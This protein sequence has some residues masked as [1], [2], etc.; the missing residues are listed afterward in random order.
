MHKGLWPLLHQPTDEDCA[1]QAAAV[2]AGDGGIPWLHGDFHES[3]YGDEP[4]HEGIQGRC[5]RSEKALTESAGKSSAVQFTGERLIPGASP[6]H[7]EAEHRARY[8]FALR[9]VRGCR[10]LDLGCGAG[11]G[12]SM[13][14]ASAT[15]VLGIDISEE[16]IEYARTHYIGSGLRFQAGDVTRLSIE[17]RRYEA[18]VCFE[19]IEHIHHPEEVLQRAARIL[20]N[21][22]IFISSTPN[23]AVKVSSIP[24]PFHCR[25]YTLN[26]YTS[27]LREQ[28]SDERWDID[29]FGQFF[30]GKTYTSLRTALKNTYLGVKG[31]LG[32]RTR[33]VAKR[34]EAPTV[35]ALSLFEFREREARL[36]EYLIAIVRSR[37]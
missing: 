24:N 10:V 29:I 15:E 3:C 28:F 31:V 14:L 19:V 22:G 7:L 33:L 16:A 30:K 27:L 8:E 6:S 37:G 32:L 11:Y 34:T 18:I 2:H 36:A 25:E 20:D 17:P 4:F 26:E 23:R 21:K 12:S 5:K 9:Y 1:S 35:D 13:L